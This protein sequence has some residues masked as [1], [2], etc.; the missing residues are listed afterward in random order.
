M[1]LLNVLH[2]NKADL[3]NI[4]SWVTAVGGAL[5]AA[6]N[7]DKSGVTLVLV[8][9]TTHYAA[10]QAA[11][12]EVLDRAKSARASVSK[13]AQRFKESQEPVPTPEEYIESIIAKIE[14]DSTYMPEESWLELA[15]LLNPDDK[16]QSYLEWCVQDRLTERLFSAMHPEAVKVQ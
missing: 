6:M 3:L 5:A 12:N 2:A 13:M 4:T 1:K 8:S 14:Q 10:R 16:I 9:M 7:H 15:Q 11:R